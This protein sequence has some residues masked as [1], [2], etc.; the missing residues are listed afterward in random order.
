MLN[1][2]YKNLEVDK[3]AKA[4]DIEPVLNVKATTKKIDKVTVV[5]YELI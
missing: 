2:L 4:N 3:N 5:G 1:H